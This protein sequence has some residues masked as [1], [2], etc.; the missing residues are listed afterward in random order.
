MQVVTTPTWNA[1]EPPVLA[2]LRL[3][4]RLRGGLRLGVLLVWTL[5]CL[6]I[7]LLALGLRRALGSQNRA[8]Q[9]V[10]RVWARGALALAGLRLRVEGRAIRVG[11]L[12]ANH[13]S[14]LDILVLCAA[15]P[16]H[17]VSKADVAAWPGVGFLARINGTVFIERRRSHAKRQEAMLRERIARSELIC[18][19]P[20]GTSTDGLR[21]LPFKSAL[22]SAFFDHGHGAQ[23]FVQ[24]VTVQ[25][26]PGPGEPPSFYGWWGSMAFE[27]HIWQV[28]CR[29]VGGRV[30]VRFHPPHDVG[31]W[32]DRKAFAE[33]CGAE[34]AAGLE[35]GLPG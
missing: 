25:Y 11:A 19:F 8:P 4:Q 32:E 1:A 14:W 13:S 30:W 10:A 35:G 28:L 23:L 33:R 18:L 27:A 6:A 22:F 16:V 9:A 34:V 20:E 12:V 17:F 15:A 29:S 5:G 24:P 21:V 26:R 2:P 7:F 3:G 31:V